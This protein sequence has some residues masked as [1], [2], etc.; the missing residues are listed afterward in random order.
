M[1]NTII[2][3]LSLLFVPNVAFPA[4]FEYDKFIGFNIGD[5]MDIAISKLDSADCTLFDKI[6]IKK[7]LFS[8]DYT[9]KIDFFNVKA[10]TV[11]FEVRKN[12]VADILITVGSDSITRLLAHFIDVE[13]RWRKNNDNYTFTFDNCIVVFNKPNGIILISK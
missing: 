8:Y 13:T 2:I 7:G 6:E 9:C 10:S 11:F 1:K 3:I 4:I 5:K 12:I